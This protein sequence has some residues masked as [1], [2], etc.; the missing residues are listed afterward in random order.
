MRYEKININAFPF[1]LHPKLA[2]YPDALAPDGQLVTSGALDV[3]LHVAKYPPTFAIIDGQ[4]YLVA[5]LLSLHLF[6]R[7]LGR[8]EFMAAI[9]DPA[10]CSED[11]DVERF[12]VSDRSLYAGLV[13]QHTPPTKSRP[14]ETRKHHLDARQICPVCVVYARGKVKPHETTL[15][16]GQDW[17]GVRAREQGG[18]VRC[19]RCKFSLRLTAGE[20]RRFTTAFSLPTS[21][22]TTVKLVNGAPIF[23][24][25]CQKNRKHGVILERHYPDRVVTRCSHC[26]YGQQ[27][28]PR[29]QGTP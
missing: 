2:A 13:A 22:V 4:T 20:F 10:E 25:E 21:E 8:A 6:M 28:S 11:V 18:T 16:A 7:T 1:L 26:P 15:T 12:A 9:C 14:T 5:N 19:K 27:T 24:P 29:D 23:C 17:R 3:V